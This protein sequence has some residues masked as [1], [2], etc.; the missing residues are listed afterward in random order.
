MT[1]RPPWQKLWAKKPRTLTDYAVSPVHD[2]EDDV[3]PNDP[4]PT[5]VAEAL[6]TGITAEYPTSEIIY[7]DEGDLVTAVTE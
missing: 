3:V 6:V 4:V 5:P 7:T 2:I 1:I